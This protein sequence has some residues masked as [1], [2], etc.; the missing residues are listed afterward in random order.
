MRELITLSIEDLVGQ[1]RAYALEQESAL[2]D[3]DTDE[4]NRL[5]DK[6]EAIDLELRTRGLEARKALLRLLDHESP[7]VRRAAAVRS[8]AISP[9]R[10]LATIKEI[11]S[12]H[13]MPEAGRAGMTL[14]H[15][16]QGIFKPT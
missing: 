2:L 14:Y 7:R 3:S 10:S 15:L 12:S 5:Y 1:F 13:L 6:M 11:A 4:Y 16:E 9:E 8:L